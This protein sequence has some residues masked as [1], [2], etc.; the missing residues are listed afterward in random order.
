[1]IQHPFVEALRT[2]A[3]GVVA[4]FL[5]FHLGEVTA[6]ISTTTTFPSPSLESHF[7]PQQTN[8][9]ITAKFVGF[10]KLSVTIVFSDGSSSFSTGGAVQASCQHKKTS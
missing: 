4:T 1:M 9:K 2:T 5:V 10:S 7:E 3:N 6:E 8:A